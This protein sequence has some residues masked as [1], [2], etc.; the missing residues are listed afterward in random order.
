MTSQSERIKP[1]PTWREVR[2]WRIA[3]LFGIIV[4]SFAALA[5]SFIAVMWL[6]APYR[7][8]HQLAHAE[9]T[10]WGVPTPVSDARVAALS[11]SQLQKFGCS[12]QVPWETVEREYDFGSAVFLQ[13]RD[14]ARLTLMNPDQIVKSYADLARSGP[15]ER[16]EYV[17]L[18]GEDAIHSSYDL[19]S[20]SLRAKPSDVRWWNSRPSHLQTAMRLFEKELVLSD[21]RSVHPLATSLIRGFQLDR[22]NGE[23]FQLLLFDAKDRQYEIDLFGNRERR[24]DTG[25]GERRI[26][27]SCH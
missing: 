6:I 2:L 16:A 15:K 18:L 10:A 21:F 20:V 23:D 22:R 5:A 26:R 7:L 4:G 27:F 17:K 3:L 1:E 11:G 9:P 19:V 8:L 12:F 14:G 13:F 25:S 24:N